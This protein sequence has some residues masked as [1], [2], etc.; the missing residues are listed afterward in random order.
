MYIPSC[1]AQN[2][3]MQGRERMEEYDV[4]CKCVLCWRS[5]LCN[6]ADSY[7]KDKAYAGQDHGDAGVPGSTDQCVRAV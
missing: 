3:G 7:G 6:R 2:N 5:D 4:I 1:F